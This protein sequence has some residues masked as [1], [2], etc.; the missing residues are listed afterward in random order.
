MHEKKRDAVTFGI[1]MVLF[2]LIIGIRY[3]SK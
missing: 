2:M 3:A 1:T